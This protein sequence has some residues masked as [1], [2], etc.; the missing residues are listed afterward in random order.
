MNGIIYIMNGI[1][2]R[3]YCKDI[4]IK[5]CYIG[6]SGNYEKRLKSHLQRLLNENDKEY[7]KKIYK[8]IRDNGGFEKFD[9]E[10]LETITS[11]NKEL[12]HKKENEFM[13]KYEYNLNEINAPTYKSKKEYDKIYNSKNTLER[14]ER[15]SQKI[16]CD[17]CNR[18]F[19]YDTKWRHQKSVIHQK[20]LNKI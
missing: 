12:L 18:T 8:F 11:C 10:I 6:S 14:K 19:R 16:T 13:E 4:N 9:F 2:Y 17:V 15:T 7:N 5:E 3:I 1:I 20:H